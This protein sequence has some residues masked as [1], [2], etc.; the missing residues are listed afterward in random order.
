M[1]NAAVIFWSGEVNRSTFLKLI[2]TL[3]TIFKPDEVKKFISEQLKINPD[4]IITAE[5]WYNFFNSL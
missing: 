2:K 4:N 3:F 5:Q 1:A